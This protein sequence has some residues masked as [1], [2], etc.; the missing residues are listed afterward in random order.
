MAAGRLPYML[1][2]TLFITDTRLSTRFNEIRQEIFGDNFPASALI[3]VVGL[4]QPG[5]LMEVQGI[6]F[7]G[8]R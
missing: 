7:L 4:A 8:D 1:A 2:M 3:T 5:M 6:T